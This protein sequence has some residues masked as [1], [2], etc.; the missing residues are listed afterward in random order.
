MAF[1]LELPLQIE[2]V[3]DDAVVHDD[4]LPGAVAVRVGVLLGR[5]AVRRP[6]RVADAVVAVERVRGQHFLEPRELPRAAPQLDRA[7]ADDG[8]ARR[9]VAAILEPPQPVDE[10][11]DDLLAADVS[12]D[13]AHSQSSVVVES[14]VD[15]VTV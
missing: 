3:L 5:P 9:V 7:V 11:G 13:S 8:H 12:D 15:L 10:D 2:V 14:S 4:D 1:L 6:A